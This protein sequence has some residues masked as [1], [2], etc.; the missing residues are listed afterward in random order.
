MDRFSWILKNAHIDKTNLLRKINKGR[1]FQTG[2]QKDKDYIFQIDKKKKKIVFKV[3]D[4]Y[5]H[6]KI[7]FKSSVLSF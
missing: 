2:S 1:G 3:L 4:T 5:M 7:V 6:L